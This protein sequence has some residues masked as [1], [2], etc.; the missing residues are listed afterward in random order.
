[1][2]NAR[3]IG[4]DIGTT[5]IC[6]L[7]LD[8]STGEILQT[9][10]QPNEACII[11][12]HVWE[13]LQDA[14]ALYSQAEAIVV[15]LMRQHGPIAGIGITG[16]MHGILY[17]DEKG[18]AVSPLFTWQDER[19]NEK[20][21]ENLSY[22][23]HLSELTGYKLATGFGAVT[24]FYN[25]ANGLVPS[26]A[27]GFCT[28]MDY[29]AMKLTNTVKPII[30]SSNAA[31]VGLFDL[32]VLDF[33]KEA[34]HR[35]K[36]NE[37]FFPRVSK[38]I[39]KIGATPSGIPVMTGIGDNQA[40]FIGSVKEASESL[41]LNIGTSSQISA[42]VK[43]Y[44]AHTKIE[45]RPLAQDQFILVGSPLCGGRSYALLENFF[46]NIAKQ[47]TGKE[48]QKLYGLMEKLAEGFAEIEDPLEI[49]TQFCGTRDNPKLRA[50]INN[51]GTNN[52]TPEHFT[53]GILQGMT[54]ELYD[55]YEE[56]KP[57]FK[58][59]PKR[60]IG[61]GNSIRMNKVL[62]KMLSRRFNMK[63]QIP[64]HKEEASYGAALSALV[65]AGVFECMRQAQKLIR[66]EKED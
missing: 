61:S 7:L 49:S 32:T 40:S 35:A 54:E 47:V 33:D 20:Y 48:V 50:S 27:A 53:V 39:E 22:A 64:I 18:E 15:E 25:T 63:I 3:V 6:A 1:M 58:S 45:T 23:Q 42:F 55:L 11:G 65:G 10:T 51:L 14:Q 26:S 12:K 41:L 13:K 30:H 31:S 36:M 17:V 28:I 59:N 24:H 66:Y 57:Q 19:G 5:T 38:T 37:D 9:I 43:A 21:K 8:G 46:R 60:L 16:Q 34:I 29:I 62:Q 44:N 4:L 2:K 52:F 56:M